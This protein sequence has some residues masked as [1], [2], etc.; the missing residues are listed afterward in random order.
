MK[1]LYIKEGSFCFIIPFFS[2]GS[3]ICD[4]YFNELN[5]ARENKN[6][7]L[8][9][10]DAEKIT[11]NF[12]NQL[13]SPSFPYIKA[14]FIQ[15]DCKFKNNYKRR[16]L[17]QCVS[18]AIKF[19]DDISQRNNTT[20]IHLDTYTVEYSHNKH[21][22]TFTFNTFL[23]ISHNDDQKTSF[24]IIDINI[25]NI[26]G[27]LFI[28]LP[29]KALSPDYIIFIKHLFYK[30][31]MKVILKRNNTEPTNYN[32]LQ[33]WITNYTTDLIDALHI[34]NHKKPIPDYVQS[35]AFK[36]SFIEIKEIRNI[37]DWP[38]DINFDNIPIFLKE[39]S[40]VTYGLLLSDEGWRSVPPHVSAN[41]LQDY[42]LTRNFSCIFFLQHNAILFN[43]KTTSRGKS[44]THAGNKWFEMYDDNK[45]VDY[46][47]SS[48]CIT[49]IDTLAL[50]VFLKVISK[51]IHIDQEFDKINPE[52]SNKTS[53]IEKKQSEIENNLNS[54]TNILNS[55]TFM[56]GE[57][58]SMEK[59]IYKQFGIFDTI[60][61]LQKKYDQLSNELHFR[62]E[63]TS[64]K[65]IRTLTLWTIIIGSLQTLIAGTSLILINNTEIFTSILSQVIRIV[66]SVFKIA[67]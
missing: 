1:E 26:N 11:K 15:K 33:E 52:D 36:Y 21:W 28:S 63:I 51:Q 19:H 14:N 32:S 40:S 4:R 66:V 45:Y 16:F 35:A 55:P 47:S 59:G 7:N 46:I 2:K 64:N 44:Y 38:T 25:T 5:E 23:Y 65:K 18:S 67:H 39:Y 22:C 49:G 30:Q 24:L 3:D 50:F 61:N 43:L 27:N 12:I 54:L 60:K 6:K 48:P 17:C 8:K 20:Q 56:L 57:M 37:N 10:E 9:N 29:S 34:R 58:Q 62:H 31:K 53:K 13:R 42:W 41:K